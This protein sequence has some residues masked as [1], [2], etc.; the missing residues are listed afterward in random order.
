VLRYHGCEMALQQPYE[1]SKRKTTNLLQ[2][3]FVRYNDAGPKVGQDAHNVSGRVRIPY[4]Q[5]VLFTSDFDVSNVTWVILCR[6]AH[7]VERGALDAK[8]VC[9]RHTSTA[10]P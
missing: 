4:P 8:V 7:P 9:S 10:R 1:L 6:I 5:L 3:Y 2:N